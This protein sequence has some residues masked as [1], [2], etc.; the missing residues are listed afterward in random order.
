MLKQ[1]TYAHLGSMNRDWAFHH[2]KGAVQNAKECKKINEAQQ[3]QLIFVDYKNA[4]QKTIKEENG[5]TTF[6]KL[7]QK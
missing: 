7:M 5:M 2:Y 3:K 1:N 4:T 6:E